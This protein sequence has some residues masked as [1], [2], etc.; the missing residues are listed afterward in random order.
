MDSRHRKPAPH[1]HRQDWRSKAQSNLATHRY[2]REFVL[3][4]YKNLLPPNFTCLP[5]ILEVYLEEPNPPLL[6]AFFSF[7]HSLGEEPNSRKYPVREKRSEQLPEWYDEEESKDTT[8][9]PQIKSSTSE[10]SIKPEEPPSEIK[11]VLASSNVKNLEKVKELDLEEKFTK[12]D[13]EVEKKLKIHSVEE[14]QELPDWDDPD[15]EDFDFEV[16]A[17]KVENVQKNE[18]IENLTYAQPTHQVPVVKTPVPIYEVNLIRYHFAIGN[19]FAQTLIDF[20]VPVGGNGITFTPNTKPFE[21]IWYYKDPEGRV[22]GAFSTLEM[23][24]W[25]IRNCFPPDLEIA[26]GGSMFFVPMN[27]FNSVPQLPDTVF[28]QSSEAS[29]PDIH[30]GKNNTN[31]NDHKKFNKTDESATLQ[32]KNMLGLNK[33]GN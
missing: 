17:K 8:T 11:L 22:H 25:T 18:K 16:K 29:N 32:L 7:T 12:V 2:R 31:K 3:K 20:G 14:D 19:P 28:Y 13:L 33:R 1:Y 6:T 27:I 9:K 23:F 10:K 24:S 4:H 30:S 15:Q 5:D 21:K 26:I